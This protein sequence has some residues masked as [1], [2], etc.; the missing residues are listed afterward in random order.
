MAGGTINTDIVCECGG[1]VDIVWFYI[2]GVA[3]R[4][5]YYT[6]CCSCDKKTIK[7]RRMENAIMDWNNKKFIKN[8]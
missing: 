4:K 1:T 8:I 6:K 3:N 7:R 2:K 5:N